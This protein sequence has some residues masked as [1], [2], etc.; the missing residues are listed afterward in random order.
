MKTIAVCIIN[1]N[2]RDLLRDCLHSVLTENADETIVVDS[3]ST[4]GS[5]EM[6][7]AEFPWIPVIALKENIGFGSASNRGIE[8]CRSEHIVLLN[9][10][11]A[12]KHG[13]LRTLSE[14]LGCHP[15]AAVIGP[16]I[17]NPD[18]TLQ[19][20]CFHYPT[21]IHIFLYISGLYQIIPRL[22]ILKNRTL[23]KMGSGSARAVP[24]LLGAALA[25]RRET[26]E[27][28]GG[29]DEAFF[30]Y[31]EEVDLCYRLSLEGQE[32]H[33][34]PQA[35]IIHVGGG[36]TTQRRTWSYIQ[37]F[38]SLAQFY[39]KHY[40]SLLLTEMVVI[41][42]AV[43]FFKLARD[44]LLLRMTRETAKKSVLV[45]DLDIHRHLLCG[46]WHR[47]SKAGMAVRAS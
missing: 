30:V 36:S 24:W 39:R 20:S 10:D 19:T 1:Y 35:E 38:S 27:A 2:T 44:F 9:A 29:F 37:F 43:A 23:Q 33:F 31:F 32:I 21:P 34:V 42:K 11:T 14:Y 28:L 8:S 12:L 40:S 13:S 7:K 26:F 15:A 6:L 41:V 4:D 5:V 18:G 16:R 46:P 3:A 22:P 47:H 25:F 45:V 17:L